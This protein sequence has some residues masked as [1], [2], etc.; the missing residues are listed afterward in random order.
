MGE[1]A[2]SAVPQIAATLNDEQTRIAATFALGQVGQMPSAAEATVLKNA[3]SDDRMLSTVSI[4]TIARI[5]PT[6]KSLTRHALEHLIG[7]LKDENSYVRELAARALLALP[8][9]PDIA[10]ALWEKAFENMDETTARN[11]LDAL[12]TLGARRC[13]G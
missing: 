9:A 10:P 11:A 2:A 4:W 7:R 5:H 1:D 12:A 8:P 13:R 3:K 6:D